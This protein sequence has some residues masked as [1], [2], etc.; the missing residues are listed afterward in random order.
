VVVEGGGSGGLGWRK[1]ARGGL[2]EVVEDE[3]KMGEKK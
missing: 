2:L 3:R 1:L